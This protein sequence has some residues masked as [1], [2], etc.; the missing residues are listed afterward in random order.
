MSC[1]FVRFFDSHWATEIEITYWGMLQ[2]REFRKICLKVDLLA[3][4]SGRSKKI[5]R[6]VPARGF[7]DIISVG[8][9]LVVCGL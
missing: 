4:L 3:Y 1:L 8:Q 6:V 7:Q 9:S 5:T 2:I